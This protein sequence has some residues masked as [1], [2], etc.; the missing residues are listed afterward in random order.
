[1]EIN[2][3]M[4]LL[5]QI[6]AVSVNE[7]KLNPRTGREG[8]WEDFELKQAHYDEFDRL[9]EYEAKVDVLRSEAQGPI[10]TVRWVDEDRA[11]GLKSRICARPFNKSSRPKDHL[12]TP[13]PA[14]AP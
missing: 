5:D 10:L 8:R 2:Y 1:M 6:A 4:D 14:D 9:V 12:F 3:I 11:S 13:T 7:E